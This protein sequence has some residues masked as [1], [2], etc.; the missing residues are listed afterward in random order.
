LTRQFS[1]FA[2]EQLMG[3]L[4]RMMRPVIWN[5]RGC[6]PSLESLNSA[7][8]VVTKQDV[9]ALVGGGTPHPLTVVELAGGK[10]IAS[11]R[12]AATAGDVVIGGLQGLHESPN[13]CDHYLLKPRLRVRL[14]KY[15]RGRALLLGCGAG[16]NYFHWLMDSVPR[17]K[18][19]QAANYSEY[20]F[21][22]LPERVSPFEGELLDLLKIPPDRRL[23]CSKNFVHQFERLVVPAMPFPHLKV[24]AWVC[25]WVRSLFPAGGSG[26]EKIFISRGGWRRRRMVNQAELEARLQRE[27]FVTIQPEQFSVAEQA[28]L[29]SSAKCVVG[30]HGAGLLN[31][32]F[33]PADALLVEL[34]HPDYI[35]LA[36][37]NMAAATGFRY[38]AVIGN[39][40]N[41]LE[42]T[43]EKQFEFG[44]EFE[45]DI[46]AVVRVIAE[47]QFC[48][49]T[50]PVP[51]R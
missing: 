5:P 49:K 21:V 7:H 42:T 24:P 11:L 13:P 10:V 8:G 9:T 14:L 30:A 2:E 33:A 44:I 25:A 1:R 47:N 41:K 34:F 23:R 28:R 27:G 31:M 32:V 37:Q 4:D 36:F 15:R 35:P 20:D 50:E 12:M 19:L 43:P 39:R 3:L 46:S 16:G 51:S 22:L 45:I 29:F 18:I 38:T 17:W 48:A 6:V 26:P 40:R